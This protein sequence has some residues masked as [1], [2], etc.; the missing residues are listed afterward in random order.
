[1]AKV[2]KGITGI[3]SIL[4][5]N[6]AGWHIYTETVDPKHSYQGFY[7]M[8]LSAILKGPEFEGFTVT[9]FGGNVINFVC[10]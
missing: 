9:W 5:E 6:R 8:P 3:R 7:D 1:M 4:A 10:D 2:A